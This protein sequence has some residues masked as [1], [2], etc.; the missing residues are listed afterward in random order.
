MGGC[1]EEPMDGQVVII[2]VKGKRSRGEGDGV[3]QDGPCKVGVQVGFKVHDTG[4]GIAR[5]DR[6]HHLETGFVQQEDDERQVSDQSEKPGKEKSQACLVG[7]EEDIV[8]QV[9]DEQRPEEP[10]QQGE[11]VQVGSEE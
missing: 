4:I 6:A 11:Q 3:R 2:E 8:R 7:R 9:R 10:E 5:K 1:A